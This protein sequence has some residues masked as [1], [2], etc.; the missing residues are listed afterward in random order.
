MTKEFREHL[1]LIARKYA[2]KNDPSHDINHFLRVLAL[3]EKIGKRERA[4][5]DIL[6][7]AALFHDVIVYKKNSRK[8][9]NA[10][11]ESA[12]LVKKILS[13]TKSYPQEKIE[14]V[15]TC[16]RECS[17]SKGIMPELLESK[18]LQDAD[19]LEATGAIAIMR[20]FSSGGQMNRQF[21]APEDP[22]C[23]NGTIRFR[24]G[25]DLFYERLLIVERGMHTK[26]AKR[27]AR[28]RTQFLRDF[29]KQFRVELQESGVL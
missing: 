18:I 17:F 25:I 10:A 29:L 2:N 7:P 23:K 4:D 11:E 15:Q 22:F 6:V 8:S 21:Y 16:I 1:I 14:K 20:T 5:M 26:D 27:M 28:G 9:K 3:V 12:S 19:R 13:K 24:S